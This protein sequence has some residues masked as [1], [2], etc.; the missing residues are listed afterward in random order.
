MKGGGGAAGDRRSIA[1]KR[2]P[3]LSNSRRIAGLLDRD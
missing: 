2:R 3:S 1:P